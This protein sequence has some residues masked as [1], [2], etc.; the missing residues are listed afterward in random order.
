M[1][2]RKRVKGLPPGVH[3]M[4]GRYYLRKRCRGMDRYFRLPELGD[5]S[6]DD[7]LNIAREWADGFADVRRTELAPQRRRPAQHHLSAACVKQHRRRRSG[8]MAGESLPKSIVDI[9]REARKRAKRK[10]ISFTLTLDQLLVLWKRSGGCCEV[11]G[12]PFS[13]EATG[14]AWR[15]YIP[16]LDRKDCGLGYDYDNVRLVCS[17][18]NAAL[19]QWGDTVFWTMIQSA[20][21]TGVGHAVPQVVGTEDIRSDLS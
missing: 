6:F 21:L 17:C 15:P 19:N 1:D 10:G 11:S 16:S 12:L 2:N 13:D 4:S 7:A 9:A 5:P 18:V 14:S 3:L 20:Y 8:V